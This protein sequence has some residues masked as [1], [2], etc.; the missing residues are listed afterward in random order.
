MAVVGPRRAGS[1]V[2]VREAI[3]RSWGAALV[4]RELVAVRG[5]RAAP[6][7]LVALVMAQGGGS[8]PR[9]VGVPRAQIVAAG[10]VQ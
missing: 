7:A 9:V 1:S 6:A 3:V 5:G 2:V 10:R 4:V 8:D